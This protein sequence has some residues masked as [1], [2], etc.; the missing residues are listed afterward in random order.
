MK[1]ALVT[2]EV[3]DLPLILSRRPSFILSV[4]SSPDSLL[5][6]FRKT[7]QLSYAIAVINSLQNTTE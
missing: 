3:Q 5:Q 7:E 4:V 1:S 6:P 2:E